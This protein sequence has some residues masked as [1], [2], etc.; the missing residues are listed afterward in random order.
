METIRYKSTGRTVSAWQDFLGIKGDGIFG[1]DTL[2]ATREWQSAWNAK[3]P[4]DRIATDGIVGAMT[5]ERAVK[6][7]TKLAAAVGAALAVIG[8][9]SLFGDTEDSLRQKVAN[10][11]AGEM[12]LDE[13]SKYWDDVMGPGIHPKDWCGAFALW[14]LHQAGLALKIKW[15]PTL[16]FLMVPPTVLPTTKTPK[17]GDI[18][19]FNKS[20][21]HA[22][23][24]KVYADGTV[25]LVNGNGYNPHIANGAKSE[26]AP[27]HVPLSAV[28]YFFSI[29]PYIDQKLAV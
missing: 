8:I 28:T 9:G 3:H 5:W 22:V 17:V 25:D 2:T 27:S 15:K 29:K 4:T 14:A 1:I 24:R 23:V 11:A 19:Y 20:Q 6:T 18:A 16:G 13:P 26:V 7:S 12:D 10:A 21:H